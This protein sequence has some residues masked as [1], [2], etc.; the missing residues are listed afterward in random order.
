MNLRKLF[1]RKRDLRSWLEYLDK[2]LSNAETTGLEIGSPTLKFKPGDFKGGD[3][4]FDVG[5][6]AV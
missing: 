1:I 6:A 3:Y 2:S 4:K 5:T